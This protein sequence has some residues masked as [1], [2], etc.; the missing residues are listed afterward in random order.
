MSE[1]SIESIFTKPVRI[2]FV[3]KDGKSGIEV[4]ASQITIFRVGLYSKEVLISRK[5]FAYFFLKYLRF[6]LLIFNR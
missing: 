5:R 1:R 3:T 4:V 2:N 6:L